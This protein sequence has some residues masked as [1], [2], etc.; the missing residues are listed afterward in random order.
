MSFFTYFS[1]KPHFPSG[2]IG[3]NNRSEIIWD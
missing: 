3:L 2:D 1:R